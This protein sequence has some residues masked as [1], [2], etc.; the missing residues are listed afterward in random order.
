MYKLMA[1]WAMLVGLAAFS[2]YETEPKADLRVGMLKTVDTIHPLI[3]RDQGYFEDDGLSVSV[4]SFGTSPALAEAIAAG[5]IDVAYM[6]TVPAGIWKAK[7]TDIV[8]LAGASRGG[9][10]LCTRDG[11]LSGS[12]AISNKGTFTQTLYDLYVEDKFDFQPVYGIEPADM[13]T[14]LLVTRD[15]DAAFV[16]EPFASAIEKGGGECIFDTGSEWEKE[17][18]TMYQRNVL[19]VSGKAAK[20]PELVRKLMRINNRTIG[21]LNQPG[22]EAAVAKAMRIEPLLR[23]RVEYNASL[24]WDSMAELWEMARENGYLSRIPEKSEILYGG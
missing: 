16:W 21:Y 17:K 10:M 24:D 6:S 5:E 1:I 7:G 13:P 4:H 20:D 8:I 19:V 3:A 23:K 22:S 2:L 12:V 9:D 18:G 15:V 11:R 14:A